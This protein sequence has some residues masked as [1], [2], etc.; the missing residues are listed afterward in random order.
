MT[1]NDKQKELNEL[2][3]NTTIKRACCLGNPE[4]N[5]S[6]NQRYKITVKLPYV[7]ELVPSTVDSGTKDLWKTFGFM[8]KEILVP[9]YMCGEFTK[10]TK[11]CPNS[12]YFRSFQI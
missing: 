2:L 1:S 11:V 8:T 10:P 9:K 12:K 7:E 3:V 6:T 4:I 5:S